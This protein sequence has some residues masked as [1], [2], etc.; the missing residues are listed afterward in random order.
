[1]EEITSLRVSR[2]TRNKLSAIGNKD[3]TFDK[4]IQRLIGFYEN[5]RG[6]SA[7]TSHRDGRRLSNIDLKKRKEAN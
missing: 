4:I 7:V 3:D 5:N 6:I 1:M 2:K